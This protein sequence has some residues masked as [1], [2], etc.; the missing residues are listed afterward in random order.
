MPIY[1]LTYEGFRG[2][3]SRTPVWFPILENTILLAFR[4][5]T[6]FWT[7][8]I[9]ALPTLIAIVYLYVRYQIEAMSSGS[10][11]RGRMGAMFVFELKSYFQFL[12]SQG[13][14]AMIIA[15]IVGSAAIGNDRR[16]NALE[17][18]FARPVTLRS[19]LLGRWLGLFVLVLGATLIPALT[20]WYF[21]NA[22]SLDPD[23]LSKT[24]SYPIR[25]AA[26]SIVHSTS[27]SLLVLAFSALISR[28]WVALAGYAGFAF[29]TSGMI[30]ALAAAVNRAYEPAAAYLKGFGYVEALFQVQHAILG[31]PENL[32]SLKT[33]T[34]TSAIWLAFLALASIGVLIRKVRPIEVVS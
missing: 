24:L 4:N 2:Q 22:L 27:V 21:D 26:W 25:L 19:Y 5:R 8:L 3:R 17:A 33:S 11:F 1:D 7:Y 20:I 10:G 16:G 6:L 12:S 18:I 9:G 30:G 28:G 23:R 13:V 34:L 31:V 15:G 29:I 14:V 32:H